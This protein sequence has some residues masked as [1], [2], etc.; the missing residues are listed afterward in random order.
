MTWV[1]KETPGEQYA[2]AISL[3]VIATIF[4]GLRF[5]TRR[6][7]KNALMWDD[8]LVLISLIGTYLTGIFIILGTALGNQ[9]QHMKFTP[10]GFPITTPEY[11]WFLKMLYAGQLS[12]IVAVGPTKIA[13]LL[14]YRRIFVGRVFE[15]VTWTLIFLVTAWSVG[16]FFA[17]MLEC[18]PISQSWASAPGQGNPH[19]ID[20]L[21]MYFSQVYSDVGL[22]CLIIIV[23]IPLVWSLQL[24][25]KQKLAVTGIFL[26]G[27]IT[28]AASC[29]KAVIFN[30]V[31]HANPGCVL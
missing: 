13:V 15:I 3:S 31:G 28:I 8:W 1:P 7:T 26:L 10:E 5:Y 6:V 23:P 20:A 4:V 2:L 27:I 14:F 29:A 12:Q 18:I 9:G 30:L 22:D 17:N 21:P 19:C 25:F 16:Y 24:P 11:T